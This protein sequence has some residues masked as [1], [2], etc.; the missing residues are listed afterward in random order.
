MLERD[1]LEKFHG[2]EALALVL[3]NFVD[4]TDIAMVQGGSGPRLAAERFESLPV[5]GSFI[6]QE[7]HR[8]KST[9]LSVLGL[10]RPRPFRRRASRRCGRAGW[11]GHHGTALWWAGRERHVNESL[12]VWQTLRKNWCRQT[13]AFT[14][15]PALRPRWAHCARRL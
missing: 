14:H 12:R 10:V 13:L 2:E 5:S 3:A 9:E 4:G 8:H 7:F 11:F 15:E 6:G 1:T